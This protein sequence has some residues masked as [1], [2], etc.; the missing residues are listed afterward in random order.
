MSLEIIPYTSLN[1]LRKIMFNFLWKGNNETEHY[2]LCK[3]ELLTL[4][5][6]YGGWGLRN[7]F[8]FNKDLTENS[9]WR[10]LMCD[11]IWNKVIID[12][13]LPPT[14]VK[15]WL[16]SLSFLHKS[17][18]GFWRGLLK[19]IHLI[20]HWLTWS[21]GSGHLIALGRDRIL[22]MGDKYFLSSPL[23]SALK[24]QNITSLL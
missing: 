5:K 2:H 9:L 13:Y 16:R 18:S 8:D 4:P 7:L 22:G 21:L 11:C 6:K 10:V 1:N 20:T 14:T 23:L 17:A 12:K 15:Y 3:W 19:A 24:N